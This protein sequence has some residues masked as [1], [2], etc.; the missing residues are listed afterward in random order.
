[1]RLEAI[2]RPSGNPVLAGDMADGLA[3]R[4]RELGVAVTVAE[5]ALPGALGVARAA[6]GRMAGEL[7]PLAPLPLY[8]DAPQTSA[9]GTASRP[10]P[11]TAAWSSPS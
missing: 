7:P 2:G 5:R 11:G 9:P 10:P 4:L 3:V 6:R 8:V 1:M